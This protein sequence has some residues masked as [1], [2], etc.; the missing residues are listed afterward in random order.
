MG[1][2]ESTWSGPTNIFECEHL[3][4]AFVRLCATVHGFKDRALHIAIALHCAAFLAMVQQGITKRSENANVNSPST[5]CHAYR[6]YRPPLR[7]EVRKM[8]R[9]TLATGIKNVFVQ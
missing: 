5:H 9:A 8:A 3:S 2:Y 4:T 1:N 7:M 6:K